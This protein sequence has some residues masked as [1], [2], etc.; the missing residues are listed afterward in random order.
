MKYILLLLCLF[1]FPVGFCV[2]AQEAEPAVANGAG[3]DSTGAEGE[4]EAKEPEEEGLSAE[5]SY[6]EMDIRTSSLMELA[7]WCR[8]LGLNDGGTRDALAARLRTHYGLPTP[9]ASRSGQRVITIESANTTEYFT[10]SAVDEEYAR[11]RGDVIISLRDG[12]AIHRIQA[13]EILYNRTRNVMTAT[14][15]VT[16]VKIEGETTETFRGHTITVNLDNWS[17]IFMDG[18]SER[19][20]SGRSS[21]YRFAGTV[22]SRN[23]ED[24]T[25]LSRATITNPASEE[26]FWSLSASKLWLLPGNDWAILNAVLRVGNIPLLYLPF[27]FYPADEIVFHPV[28]G[29]RSREG[30]YLQTTTY[31]LGRP[32]ASAIEENSITRIFGG[33]DDSDKRREGIFLRSTGERIFDPRNIQLSVLFDIYANLGGYLGTELTLPAKGIFGETSLSAGLGLTR[34]LYFVGGNYTPFRNHDGESDWN[35]AM[36]LSFN[37]PFRYRINASGS[38]K[39]NNGTLSWELPYYSDP[40]V[41]RDFLLRSESMDWLGMLRDWG[42]E[43]PV[44]DSTRSSYE[45]RLRGSFSP[46]VR[47]LNPYLSSFSIS[48]MTSSLLFSER[49]S[50]SYTGPS[51]PPNPSRA[52]FFPNRFTIFSA[53]AAVAGTP[54][55][56]RVVATERERPATGPAPGDALLP[57]LPIP[58]WD[59]IDAQAAAARAIPDTYNFAPPVLNQRFPFPPSTRTQLSVDYRLSPTTATEMQ[60]RS[61]RWREQDEVNWGDVASVL[62]SFRSDGNVGLNLTQPGGGAYSGSFRLSGTGSFRDYLF[63]NEAAE[64]FSGGVQAAR[65]RAYNETFFNSNWDLSGTLRP[66]SGNLV[67]GNTNFQYSLRGLLGKTT[68]DTSSPDPNWD[69]AFGK[70]DDTDISSHQVTANV[71][72]NLRDNNQT[73]SVSTVLPPRDSAVSGNI[74]LRAWISETSIRGRVLF[75]FDEEQRK[76]EPVTLTE[77]LRFSTRS[78]F[79]QHVVYDPEQSEFTTLTSSLNLPGFTASFSA[80]FAQP[81]LYNYHG[82]VDPGR[83]DGWVQLPDRSLNP[84]ELRFAYRNTFAQ[85]NLWENRLNYSLALNSDLIFDLQRYTNTRLTFGLEASFKVTN[86][87]DLRFTSRTENVVMFKYFQ[88]LPFFDL[89]TQLYPGMESNIFVDLLNSFRFDNYDLRRQSGFKLKALDMSLVHH[90][91]DWDAR[92]T[93]KMTPHLPAGSR[94][95]RFS[96]EISF[97]VQWIPITELNTK[98][99]YFQERLTIK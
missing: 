1:L 59:S 73:L 16:Y 2:F 11:L 49:V 31:V 52:F 64:E 5:L 4:S 38:F 10:L 91:G 20:V 12:N 55:S 18:V 19:A 51:A 8:E 71:A 63:L 88:G 53:S 17:S 42:S 33:A 7:A 65:N 29:Y 97:M 86:F 28:L 22:I 79:Q 99:D 26:V 70:W 15:N 41:D 45:W 94:S 50:R 81:Y 76:I 43:E 23:D 77:T 44:T 6:I 85:N 82:S 60:F 95:Y 54:F 80:L 68:V 30:T 89:P 67:W 84:H 78:S 48:S 47:H 92:L 72:A 87:M 37:T 39:I 69:W 56:T 36:F 98:I 27:F 96:N 9:A 21:A 46:Q 3:A 93:M 66:F 13:W 57:D 90:L 75:P 61:S 24:V 34:D 32:T 25:V 40:Y 58:P 83:P 35:R 74:G 14:G 62:T